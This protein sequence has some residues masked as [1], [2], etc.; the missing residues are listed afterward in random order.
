MRQVKL[1]EGK[2]Q[3]QFKDFINYK[4]RIGKI[5]IAGDEGT[6]K[7]LLLTRI[8]IGKM[9]HWQDY[10]YKAYDEIDNRNSLGYHF[11]KD[12]EHLCFANYDIVCAGTE[13][14]STRVYMFNPFEFGLYND[15]YDTI[16]LPPYSLVC[17]TE[18]KNYLDSYMYTYYRM[19]YILGYRTARQADIDFVVDCQ[20]FSDVVTMFR[21][22]TNRFIYLYKKCEVIYN[23]KGE[24][25][26]HK[27]FVYEF[28]NNQDAELYES[29]LEKRNCK[30][31]ELIIDMNIFPCY[32]TKFCKY[33][34][35]KGRE[36][37]DYHIEHFPEIKSIDD[38]EYFADQ[39][40][41]VPPDN[42]YKNSKKTKNAEA[43]NQDDEQPPS[44]EYF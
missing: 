34:H 40:G 17:I 36:L 4:D 33:L 25:V 5:V 41:G 6:G 7:T 19:C 30:E 42:F 29:S 24:I 12:F 15:D 2:M 16:P 18:G 35:L 38:V 37:Q 23:L 31:Y 10:I 39:I 8:A 22:I 20:C 11:S 44:D 14:P 28:E 1:S 43:K 27:L 9:L 32:D 21:R 13:I 26:G 3:V